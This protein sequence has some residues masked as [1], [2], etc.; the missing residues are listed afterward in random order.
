[1]K[2]VNG[3]GQ[4]LRS[5]LQAARR[6]TALKRESLSEAPLM[7]FIASSFIDYAFFIGCDACLCF[8]QGFAKSGGPSPHS[9]TL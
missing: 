3:E 7:I 2:S 9:F 5:S 8:L 1:L 6:T 4:S